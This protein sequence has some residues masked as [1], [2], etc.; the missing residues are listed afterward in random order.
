MERVNETTLRPVNTIKYLICTEKSIPSIAFFIKVVETSIKGN[1]IG[2]PKIASNVK[3][4][5]AFEAM[6]D[7]KLKMNACATKYHTC[8]KQQLI[9][10]LDGEQCGVN[11]SCNAS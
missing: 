9:V 4:L 7:N 11:Q 3:L 1:M 5:P 10:N 8:P 2:N 6:V